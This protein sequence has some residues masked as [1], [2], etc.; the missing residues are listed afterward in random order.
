[1]H[2]RVHVRVNVRVQSQISVH[3]AERS[4]IG[5]GGRAGCNGAD[6]CR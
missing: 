3:V 4:N 2:V 5:D 1:V 6:D